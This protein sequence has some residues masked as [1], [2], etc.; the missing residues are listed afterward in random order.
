V[1]D[2][3]WAGFC[4]SKKYVSLVVIRGGTW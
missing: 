4:D 1:M 2:Q 3:G